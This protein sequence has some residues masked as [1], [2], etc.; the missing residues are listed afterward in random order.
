MADIQQEVV[1]WLASQKGWQ[2]ELAFRVMN[3]TSL[4]DADYKEIVAMLK[5]NIAYDGK[6]FPNIG[7]SVQSGSQIR[8]QSIGQVSNIEGLAPRNPL[9]LD[10]DSQNLVVVYGDNGSGK[11]GYTRIIK[12][13][14][15][16]SGTQELLHNIFGT[17]TPL[18]S[19]KIQY[20]LDG[21]EREINWTVNDGH[22]EE[23]RQ[24][25]IFDSDTA[26]TYI[27][28]S[29]RTTYT[30]AII[31][32]F[33]ALAVCYDE[34]KRRLIGTKNGLISALPTLPLSYTLTPAGAL[35]KSLKARYSESDF[36]ILFP[37]TD[38]NEKQLNSLNER[39]AATDPSKV[40]EGKRK[41]KRELDAIVTLVKGAAQAISNDAY[42]ELK[43]LKA[44]ADS[45]RKIAD[46][47]T[48]VLSGSAIEGVGSDS[49][50]SL[51]NAAKEFSTQEAY[52]GIEF[53][54]VS[55]EARCVLCHQ[56]LSAD[57]TA[58]FKSFNDYIEG[59]VE[60]DAA[61]A[62]T[63]YDEK[64]ASLPKPISKEEMETKCIAAG[65]D[66]WLTPIM[67]V[68]AAMVEN[69][70]LMVKD[71]DIIPDISEQVNLQISAL[72]A[73]S[74]QYEKDALKLEEDAQAF[75]RAQANKAKVE[76]EAKKWCSEQKD[77]I[78]TE[79]ARLKKI[80]QYD[81][82]TNGISTHSLTRKANEISEK[83]VTEE[84]VKRFNEELKRLGAQN[85]RVQFISEGGKG[86]VKHSMAIVGING[87]K[88]SDILSDG[89]FRIVA[90]AAFLADVTG[91]NNCNPFIFDD[92][93]SSLD[94][95]FEERTIDRLVELSKDRQ[96]IVFTHRLSLLG[97]LS[98][99]C[100]DAVLLGIKK[101]HWGTG[102]IGDTPF[103]AKKP[104]KALSK[105]KDESVPKA[106]RVLETDG[107]DF[108]E[109]EAGDICKQVRIQIERIVELTLLADVVQRY[110]RAVN[111]A[112][113]IHKLAA[114]E[115]EDCALID[116]FMTK[117]SRYEHSQPGEI[118]VELPDPQELE[119][120]LTELL[121]WYD[122]FEKKKE[123]QTVA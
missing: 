41:N 106:K 72:E 40:A 113:K 4:S 89:E 109:R 60:R 25:D 104:N 65:I 75:D 67:D 5:S 83:T 55:E 107:K 17:K 51:W 23:L 93:I 58:R 1:D 50:K 79:V 120:D 100:K 117:Y 64:I 62:K 84:Y 16:K 38:D 96:V 35:Y 78:L 114:I 49:W 54:N 13:I 102:E 87:V 24:V 46:E 76:L 59:Q 69:A 2:K 77:A 36:V 71:A 86:A 99:K 82:W 66:D 63:L 7:R 88:P 105:L 53:P 98:E 10:K 3:Q 95:L 115:K 30:P 20:Q 118:R 34:V 112:G 103:F 85:I 123:A 45:K 111:T 12:K 90:L 80:E 37:W 6:P 121:V 91:G 47:A 70:N 33:E 22:I 122:G 48:Q 92:P 110:R 119:T 32:F 74:K 18:G 61:T 44:D 73:K 94:Q 108:Y 39:L 43:R 101:E 57:T 27:Q 97:L 15:G 14:C 42:A 26:R 11:S 31:S 56:P 29:Q 68:R 19:C 81:K 28:A 8:L 52:K 21:D 116:K 9:E